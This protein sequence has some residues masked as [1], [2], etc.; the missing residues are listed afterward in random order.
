MAIKAFDGDT[1]IR[2]IGATTADVST[3]TINLPA[4][5]EKDDV[6]IVATLSDDV[7]LPNYPTGYTEGQRGNV[8]G[9]NIYFMWAYKVMGSPP[10][11]TATGLTSDSRTGHVALAF[12]NISPSTPLDVSPPPASGGGTGM[13]N[14]PSVTTS[15]KSAIVSLGFLDDD[16]VADTTA[17]SGYTL[18]VNHSFGTS[19]NGGTLMAAYLLNAVAGIYDPDA[20]G[21]SGNDEW[22]A[23]TVALREKN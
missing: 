15:N 12:R 13:P 8:A 19:G 5:L 17:P 22:V 16:L 6:I 7:S 20:F 3:S 10:D 18:A 11:S 4:G 14:S 23:A 21:G 2:F 9:R 1:S